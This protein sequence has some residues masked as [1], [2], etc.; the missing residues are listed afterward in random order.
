VALLN[1]FQ[2][3]CACAPNFSSPIKKYWWYALFFS[4]KH[5]YS[6]SRKGAI[7]F[8]NH[9]NIINDHIDQIIIKLVKKGLLKAVA[10]DPPI[11]Y[12]MGGAARIDSSIK[13]EW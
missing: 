11:A 5:V 10:F 3:P 8:L 13:W 7:K 9:V 6:F 4:R 12:H 2:H 1:G